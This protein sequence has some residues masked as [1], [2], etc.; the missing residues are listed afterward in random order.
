MYLTVVTNFVFKRSLAKLHCSNHTLRIQMGRREGI[1]L[2]NRTCKLCSLEKVEEF[3]FVV[4]CP[5]YSNMR[6]KYFPRHRRDDKQYFIILLSSTNKDVINNFAMYVHFPFKA[7]NE[8]L[9]L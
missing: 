5:F 9:T 8:R 4:D 2:E 7:R 1:E 6:D 3:H